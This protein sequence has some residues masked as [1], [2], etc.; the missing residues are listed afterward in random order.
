[1]FYV[2]S[3]QIQCVLSCGP[4]MTANFCGWAAL[5][6][7]ILIA[8]QHS[9]TYERLIWNLMWMDVNLQQ[10]EMLK[11]FRCKHSKVPAAAWWQLLWKYVIINVTFQD[12]G[13]ENKDSCKQSAPLCGSTGESRTSSG[14]RGH[15]WGRQE[16][17]QKKVGNGEKRRGK[18]ARKSS[19]A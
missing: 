7:Q 2:H 8:V 14:G 5:I 19:S 18:R 9:C 16:D 6:G 17:R 15:K 11:S 13:Q 4:I 3:M 1:M 12:I 10:R